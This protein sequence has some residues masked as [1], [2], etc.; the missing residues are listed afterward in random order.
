MQPR[1]F[2]SF[3]EFEREVIRPGFRPGLSLEDIVSDDSFEELELF[4][5]G[6]EEPDEE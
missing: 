4:S 6:M 1:S 3:A 5:D 2:R